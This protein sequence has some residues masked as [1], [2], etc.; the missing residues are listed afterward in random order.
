VRRLPAPVSGRLIRRGFLVD[1]SKA[2]GVVFKVADTREELEAAYRLVH[3][4]YVK[5]GYADHHGAG[6]RVNLRYALPTTAT[7]VGKDDSGEVVITMTA[8]GD[9]PLGL[10]MDMIFSEELYGLRRQGRYLVEVGALASHPDFRRRQQTLALYADKAI[11]T[12]AMEY[13]GAD[14]MV[15]AINPKHV[16]VYQHLLLFDVISSGVKQYHYVK[17]APAVAMRLDFRTCRKRWQRAY[18]GRPNHRSF[19]HF[20][21]RDDQD[22][23]VLPDS[24]EPYKV[25]DEEMFSYFF[26]EKTDPRRE[27]AGSLLNLYRILYQQPGVESTADGFAEA[28]LKTEAVA[29]TN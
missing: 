18:A 5:E 8:I 10:P 28:P 1:D 6:I 23:I 15:I 12:Y 25:W 11:T 24:K 19:F 21:C 20:F 14:D 7:I 22:R 17:G 26:E 13:L 29:L 9:S 27:G 4:V 16:W 3:D 2:E